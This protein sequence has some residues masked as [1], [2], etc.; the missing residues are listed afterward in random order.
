MSGGHFEYQQYRI[1]D[2]AFEIDEM[3]GANDDQ[4]LDEWGQRRGNNYP[5]EILEKFQ[6]TAH[7]LRQA[8]EMAQRVDWL[9]SS[10]DGEESFLRRWEKEVRPYWPNATA[11]ETA[12]LRHERS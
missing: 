1:E 9:V 8:A 3:I 4:S 11:Q 7:T 10:D 2:I 6:E 5:P 12:G